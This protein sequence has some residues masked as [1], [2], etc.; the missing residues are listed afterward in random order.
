MPS[1]H[2]IDGSTQHFSV[3]FSDQ[4]QSFPCNH[5]LK[6]LSEDFYTRWKGAILVVHMDIDCKLKDLIYMAKAL[7][8]KIDYHI[9]TLTQLH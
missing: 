7:Q 8:G 5:G 3:D 9:H 2:Q 6:K 4:Q 1:Q